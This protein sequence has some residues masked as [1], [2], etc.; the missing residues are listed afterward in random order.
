MGDLQQVRGCGEFTG[1]PKRDCGLDCCKKLN[2]RDHNDGYP[3][4]PV[5]N[6]WTHRMHLN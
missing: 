4:Q 2:S 5:E 3:N 6:S 1:V